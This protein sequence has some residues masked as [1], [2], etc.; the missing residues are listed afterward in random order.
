MP[1]FAKGKVYYP[2]VEDIEYKSWTVF[3]SNSTLNRKGELIMGT[4][5]ALSCKLLYPSLPKKFGNMIKNRLKYTTNPAYG[6]LVDYEHACIALQTKFNWK[7]D[8]PIELVN[9]SIKEFIRLVKNNPTAMFHMPLPGVSNGGLGVEEIFDIL[10][11]LP[12]NVTVNCDEHYEDIVYRI[13]NGE[14][15]KTRY[16]AHKL[17]VSKPEQYGMFIRYSR[18][19]MINEQ[20]QPMSFQDLMSSLHKGDA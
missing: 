2:K 14:F 19:D 17:T 8:S 20:A 18:D 12:R 1:L 15:A 4:G 5:S 6:V 13:V 11:D 7:D 10:L 9:S 16:Q 3:T